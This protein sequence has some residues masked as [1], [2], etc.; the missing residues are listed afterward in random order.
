[1]STSDDH[2]SKSELKRRAQALVDLGTRLTE[3]NSET[4][5]RIPMSDD[6]RAALAESARITSNSASKRHR[7]YIGRL[8]RDEDVAAIEAAVAML[9]ASS[10]AARASFHRLEQWRDDLLSGKLDANDYMSE[11]PHSDRSQLRS[12]LNRA[13]SA[14]DEASRKK[15][16][17]ALFRWLRDDLQV[18][19]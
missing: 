2:P 3:I 7:Q 11:H 19:D 1:M 17:R 10:H 12:L 5:D 14:P 15:H 13:R 6:L 16:A 4:L 8:L 18:S 9:D